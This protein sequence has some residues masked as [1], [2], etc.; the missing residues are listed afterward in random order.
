M[1]KAVSQKLEVQYSLPGSFDL[2][3][4]KDCFSLG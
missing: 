2:K 3:C 1:W 4:D